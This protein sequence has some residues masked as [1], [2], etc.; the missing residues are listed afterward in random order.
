[1]L[2]VFVCTGN[3]CRSPM[4]EGFA[5]A[6]RADGSV[7]FSSAGTHAVSGTSV[8][9]R[10]A[11][12]MRE[13]GI[14]IGAHEAT[15]LYSAAKADP[16]AVYTMTSPQAAYIR[17]VHPELAATVE[18]LDPQGNDIADPYGRELADYRTARD[19]IE[20]AVRRRAEEWPR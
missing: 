15:D 10:A 11:R 4:A 7:S 9:A 17:A 5:R 3:I 1:M 16:D 14:D 8:S 18:L 6:L 19:L 20:Q 2:I 12:V 13:S